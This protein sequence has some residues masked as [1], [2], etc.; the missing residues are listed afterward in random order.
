MFYLLF[1]LSNCIAISNN[2]ALNL[3]K[4]KLETTKRKGLLWNISPIDFLDI[5]TEPYWYWMKENSLI[6]SPWV[7]LY[8]Q[9]GSKISGEGRYSLKVFP[10]SHSLS[11]SGN[12]TFTPHLKCST[13]SFYVVV[14]T[15]LHLL[16]SLQTGR[17][18]SPVDWQVDSP[19]DEAS[20]W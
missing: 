15:E 5:W 8:F 7:V 20:Y 18:P 2:T 19:K 14:P 3:I 16:S 9:F 17:M 13:P 4:I 6:E 11:F 12:D 1:I 10:T